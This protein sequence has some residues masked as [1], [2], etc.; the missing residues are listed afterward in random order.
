MKITVGNAEIVP[1]DSSEKGDTQVHNITHFVTPQEKFRVYN[2][3]L[4]IEEISLIDMLYRG[5]MLIESLGDFV[6]IP[7][8]C[9]CHY[10]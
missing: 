7:A 1:L 3:A 2:C 10:W 6:K 5:P 8:I 4:K 9:L